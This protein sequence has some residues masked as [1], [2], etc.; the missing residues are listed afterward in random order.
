MKELDSLRAMAN[1]VLYEGLMLYPYRISALKNQ[2]PGWS[3]GSLLPPAYAAA[4]PG[5][6][7]T[8]SADLLARTD[9]TAELV[10]EARFLQLPAAEG[11]TIE[12]EVL[13]QAAMGSLLLQSVRV[14]FRFGEAP[15]DEV[16]GDLEITAEALAPDLVRISIAVQNTS[17]STVLPASR[18]EAL[19]QALISAHAVVVLDRGEW[20]SLLDPP[21][22][23]RS[24]A[25]S[26]RHQ[27]VF[28]VLAGD[29]AE[30]KAML[31][32]P[33]ILYDFPAIAPESRGDFFD[34]T[35]IDEM[36]TLR[37]L[38]LSD[39]EKQELRQGDPGSRRIL[40]RVEQS[41]EHDLL[42]LH[43]VLREGSRVAELKPGDRV[44]L[45]PRRQADIFDM[46]LAGRL[47]TI[48]SIEMTLENEIY[49]A[50]IVDDDPGADLGEARQIGHRFFFHAD[51]VEAVA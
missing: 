34:S 25:D 7:D 37:V 38:T 24:V 20:V 51:E 30:R 11:G 17:A 32:S 22:D 18:D 41:P 12:R 8:M 28:P 44:R 39:E 50:V 23:L 19:R 27:G 42:R 21:E 9:T 47:A 36:L 26:C 46:A 3:F 16:R 48:A 49:F 35:E 4:H 14:P 13:A 31:L 33:I 2:R 1:A 5:E 10:V 6:S 45:R 40:E 29:P 43:G 15:G